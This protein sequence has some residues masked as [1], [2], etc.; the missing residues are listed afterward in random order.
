MKLRTKT[1]VSA[2]LIAGALGVVGGGALAYGIEP[3]T[4]YF[5]NEWT[6]NQAV[7]DEVQQGTPIIQNCTYA[8]RIWPWGTP[9]DP[10]PW[11]AVFG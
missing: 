8:G 1:V 5:V 11:L 2:A 9:M 3:G 4:H 6:C 7:R 10:G